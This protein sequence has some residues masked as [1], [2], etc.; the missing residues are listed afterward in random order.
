[1]IVKRDTGKA[2][3][4]PDTVTPGSARIASRTS[5]ASGSLSAVNDPYWDLVDEPQE[6]AFDAAKTALL[7]VDMQNMCAH[8]D[9]WMG[10]LC[11][12]RAGPAT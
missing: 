8:P 2:S 4:R 9:G 3:H 5:R 6:P 7:I 12:I 10:R 1:M 11:V